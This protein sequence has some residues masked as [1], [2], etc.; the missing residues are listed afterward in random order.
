V[1]ADL[2]G[3][4]RDDGEKGERDTLG[5]DIENITGGL[6]GDVLTG[7]R[8]ANDIDGGPGGNDTI[9]GRAGNDTLG[10]GEGG[11]DRLYG[12]GGDDTLDGGWED[13]IAADRLDGGANG[14]PLGDSCTVSEAD[15]LVNCELLADGS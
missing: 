15:A 13:V 4:T 2:D 14:T 6:A 12:E 1:T 10:G 3:A 7:N 5:A 9:R 11:K 8:F